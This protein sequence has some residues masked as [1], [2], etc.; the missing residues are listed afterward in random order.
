MPPSGLPY[1]P[2]DALAGRAHVVVDGA[3]RPGSVLVLSHWPS[4][5]APAGLRRDLSAEMAFAWLAR[6]PRW[7]ASAAAVTTD[8]LDEDGLAALLALVDPPVALARRRALVAL[9]RAGDF[10]VVADAAAARLVFAVR[11]VMGRDA[12]SGAPGWRGEEV[13]A[14]YEELLGRLPELIDHPERFA[15]LGAAEEARYRASVACLEVGEATIEEEPCLGLA[16]VRVGRAVADLGERLGE[17][18]SL[19]LHPAALHSATAMARVALVHGD[20]FVYYDRYETWVAYTSRRLP[21]RR[22]L[23]PLAGRLNEAEGAPVW[24][25][26]PPGALVPVLAHAP[27]RSSRLPPERVLELVRRYLASA[28]AAWDPFLSVPALGRR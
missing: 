19:P 12:P 11:A 8:H 17:R 1:V 4:T 2:V 16:V 5:P 3:P 21:R 10:G 6:H 28:P 18:A 26:D 14:R 23:E 27:G 7:P 15:R 20:R 13:G 22:D 24:E 9:A 25:A